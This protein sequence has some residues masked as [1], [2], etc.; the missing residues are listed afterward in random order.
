MNKKIYLALGLGMLACAPLFAQNLNPQVQVTNDY[1]ARMARQKKAEL[2][3]Q[4][5]DSLTRF[6]TNID[7]SVFDTKYQGAYE[8]NPYA[9]TVV[10]E[11]REFSGNTLFLKAGAGYS[12]HPLAELVYTPKKQ[13]AFRADVY[14]GFKGYGGGFNRNFI[15]GREDSYT[16]SGYD[17][18]L[19]AGVEARWN[20]KKT[21]VYANLDY[22][23]I[24]TRDDFTSG[25]YHEASL[26]G[27]VS[28]S[29]RDVPFYY[30][31]GGRLF[32]F[33][34]NYP[35]GIGL[36]SLGGGGF[37]FQASMGPEIARMFD[38]LIDVDMEGNVYGG[39]LENSFTTSLTPKAVFNW[40][41]LFFSA[42]FSLGLGEKLGIYPDIHARLRFFDDLFALYA[43]VTGGQVLGDYASFK[44]ADHWFNLSYIPS[45]GLGVS[46]DKFKFTLGI[47]GKLADRLQYDLYG[48]YAVKKNAVL[49]SVSPADFTC[50]IAYADYKAR[51]AGAGL[52]WKS[53]RL[54]I[55]G[56]MLYQSTD[57]C[58]PY[59]PG[60]RVEFLDNPSWIAPPKTLLNLRGVYNWNHRIFAGLSLSGMDSRAWNANTGRIKGFCL[61]G[62]S[63]EYL[64]NRKFSVWA[65]L[66]NI[67]NQGITLAPAH[68]PGG[69]NFTAGICL[70]LQ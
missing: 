59:I 8:F 27:K 40:R 61:L 66:D 35:Q 13:G 45:S 4:V 29:S 31:L 7:Y 68:I 15:S 28:S 32:L 1:E 2:Y 5:P 16:F 9:V 60:L 11:A 50:G 19:D 22:D 18:G 30:E 46:E 37:A 54:E 56:G 6:D 14:G 58:E 69:I 70:R 51:F 34:D 36:E 64:L 67:L 3:M 23:G 57:L 42:G 43:D 48:G 24:L 17:Y 47:S 65:K 41:S 39:S 55:D 10:P 33:R 20:R 62:T 53:D 63:F 12:F 49:N 21:N 44:K 26:S 25:N 52:A 38:L